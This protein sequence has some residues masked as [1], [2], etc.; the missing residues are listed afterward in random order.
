[1]INILFL[2]TNFLV[3]PPMYMH[4]FAQRKKILGTS[5]TKPASKTKWFLCVYINLGV[6]FKFIE[7][8]VQWGNLSAI[9][10]VFCNADIF[11]TIKCYNFYFLENLRCQFATISASLMEDHLRVACFSK[12]IDSMYQKNVKQNLDLG[13]GY[14]TYLNFKF[15]SWEWYPMLILTFFWKLKIY[16]YILLFLGKPTVRKKSHTL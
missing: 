11:V 16:A 5:S 8:N 6:K 3:F 2:L 13:L 14:I 12:D 9:F 4:M 1:M 15:K 7:L 10:I